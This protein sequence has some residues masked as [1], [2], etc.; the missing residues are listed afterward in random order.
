MD[1]LHL[2]DRLEELVGAAH[3]VPMSKK[4]LLDQQ[5]LLELIDQI[6]VAIPKE[7]KEATE[8]TA[9][10]ER[11][12]MDAQEESRIM[13]ARAE[14]TSSHLIAEHNIAES[15]RKRAQEIADEAE[16]RLR[17]RVDYA[18]A[19]IQQRIT[20]SREVAQSQMSDADD[21]SLEL[22]RRLEKQLNLYTDSVGRA[23]QQLD[24]SQ[25]AEN[26]NITEDVGLSLEDELTVDEN[27]PTVDENESA[28][29]EDEPLVDENESAVDEDEPVVDENESVVEEDESAADEDE[30]AVDEDEPAV[31]EDEP[32]VDLLSEVSGEVIDDFDNQPLDDQPAQNNKNN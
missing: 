12:F 2:V 19:E 23:I 8:I 15:A 4:L 13:I 1:L 3:R 22:L 7:V 27:E 30:P 18:N 10:R 31:D 21:Y 26:I 9:Q 11:I 25:E 6:R 28:V 24:A 14:Q 16:K 20:D 29:D 32:L 5:V 17:E